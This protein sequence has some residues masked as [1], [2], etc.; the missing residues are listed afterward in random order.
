MK[1]KIMEHPIHRYARKMLS[2]GQLENAQTAMAAKDLIDRL[3]DIIADLGKMSNDEL[4]H[5]VDSARDT[6]GNDAATRYSSDAT[7][8]IDELLSNAKQ[9]KSSLENATL[10][11]TGDSSPESTSG[12]SDLE[13]P[14]E[15]K[16]EASE[17]EA[18]D[19]NDLM[20]DA[21]D[22]EDFDNIDKVTGDR[23]KRI[24]TTES[25][26]VLNQ[27]I[28]ALT[29]RLRETQ[30]FGDV[31][32]STLLQEEINNLARKA[33]MESKK[34]AKKEAKK[35]PKKSAKKVAKKAP[36]KKPVGKKK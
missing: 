9:T 24:P 20:M 4:P 33:I 28:V 6:F 14:G 8:I 12:T 3:Q 2:E 30:E 21:D 25:V 22:V 11:L 32:R 17:D 10:V 35:A 23:E 29:K 19:D 13:L 7:N 16:S 15:D 5:V 18:L 26:A 1:K 34:S 27:K 36:V 31:K